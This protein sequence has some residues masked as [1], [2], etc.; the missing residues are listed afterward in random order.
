MLAHLLKYDSIYRR[1]PG[2]VEARDDALVISDAAGSITVKSLAV[3]SP[4]ELPWADLGVD[5]VLEST[6]LF[7]DV[8]KA[9]L[10]LE[11]GA[12]RVV[13]SA[14]AKGDCRTIVLGVNEG[15]YDPATD[16]IVSNASCT[17]NCLAPICKVLNDTYGIEQGF[18]TTIHS[19]TND[20]RLLD[21]PHKDLRRAR[22][23]ALN[24]IPTTTGAAKAI[25]LVIP[26]LK[27]K[28]DGY[29]IRIPTPTGSVVDLVCT[30]AKAPAD[31]AEVN[32][33]FAAAASSG[34]LAPYLDYEEDAIVTADIVRVPG[35]VGHSSRPETMV[36]GNMIKVLAWYDNEWGYS[37]RTA[38][39]LTYMAARGI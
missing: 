18:M 10:H 29:S 39:L 1:F 32:A 28:L 35:V 11:A 20:Q 22:A 12:K 16:K 34:P 30:L 24:I 9:A 4:A 14:P 15:D 13:L 26:A 37:N 38:D 7:T 36:S 8:T 19:Y 25:G 5:F 27:G 2:T 21:F 31:S 6:G 23:A 33:A 17:T 3:R